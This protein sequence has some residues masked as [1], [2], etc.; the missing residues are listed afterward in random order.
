MSR[1]V[2]VAY[3]PKPGRAS[4][5]A[6]LTQSHV[7]LLRTEGLVT[8]RTPIVMQA[9]DGSVVEVFEWKSAE[10]IEQAHANLTVQALWQKYAEVCDYIPVGDV[11][12]SACLFSEFTPLN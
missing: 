12:E 4:D 11:V 10:A 9:D 3:K 6:K 5:L 8:K 1:I 7:S 2:I